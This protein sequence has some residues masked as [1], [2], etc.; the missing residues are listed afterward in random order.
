MQEQ[1]AAYITSQPEPKRSD[2]QALHRI[3]PEVMP[4]CK[5][6]FLDV[7][8][9]ENKTVSNPNIGYETVLF[10]LFLPSRNHNLHAGITS[11]MMRCNACIS[12]HFGSGWLVIYFSICSCTFIIC[13][14]LSILRRLSLHHREVQQYIYG[15]Y[16]YI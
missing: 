3:I 2:M 12:L 16:P 11:R 1:I 7:K 13:C 9:S 10:S 15:K 6:W 14:W 5:L 4:A 8:N